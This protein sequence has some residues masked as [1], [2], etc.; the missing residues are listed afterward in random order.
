MSEPEK[1]TVTILLNGREVQA[2]PTKPLIHACLQADTEVPH[3]CYHPG[4]SPVGSC[5]IC[6]VQ[7]KQG[8]MPA[9]V[10]V[11]CRT[12]VAAGIGGIV[13]FSGER[14]TF[15]LFKNAPKH[16]MSEWLF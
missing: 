5:R 11:A 14:I 4:L 13:C 15:N 2:D 10:V 7:V 12:P 1:G 16:P 3:Y 8:E 6:Q 9:R